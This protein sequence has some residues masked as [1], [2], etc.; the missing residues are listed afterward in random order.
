MRG[1]RLPGRGGAHA[2]PCQVDSV[3]SGAGE[4]CWRAGG[5][6][7]LHFL[8][9]CPVLSGWFGLRFSKGSEPFTP[10][11]FLALISFP[12]HTLWRSGELA[13]WPHRKGVAKCCSPCSRP[14]P[15]L[16]PLPAFPLLLSCPD[17]VPLP[18]PALAPDTFPLGVGW[19]RVGG[20]GPGRPR[21]VSLRGRHGFP[22]KVAEPL[23]ELPLPLR[24]RSLE[25]AAAL[26]GATGLPFSV[27]RSVTR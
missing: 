7:S 16:P 9:V 24:H 21:P 8:L 15:V 17:F 23:G 4:P 14:C 13:G 18:L 12:C 26:R 5:G 10:S 19:G 20:R 22:R 3:L 6:R 11:L 1:G 25:V 2:G 27:S